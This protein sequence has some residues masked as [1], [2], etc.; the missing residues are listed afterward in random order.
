IDILIDLAGHTSRGRPLLLAMKPA[1]IQESYLGYPGTTGLSTVDYRITDA[2]SDP[3]GAS[4][5]FHSEKLIRLPGCFVCFRADDDA[6]PPRTQRE[7]GPILFGS[8][9]NLGKLSAET[10]RLWG[11]ILAAV[12]DSR[13]LLKYRSLGDP[14]TR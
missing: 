12:P 13:L 14:G 5:A 3:P 1:P 9:N 2:L 4:D 10:M 7:P 6:P 11:R 8:F